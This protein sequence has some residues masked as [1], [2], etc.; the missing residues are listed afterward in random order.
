MT[1]YK[2]Q[3]TNNAYGFTNYRNLR[4]YNIDSFNTRSLEC[5][6]AYPVQSMNKKKQVVETTCESHEKTSRDSFQKTGEA[7]P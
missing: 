6:G 3:S 5:A 2:I 1:G 4:R 7:A